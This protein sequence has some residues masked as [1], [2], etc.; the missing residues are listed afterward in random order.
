MNIL[1]TGNIKRLS[2]SFF[3]SVAGIDNNENLCVLYNEEADERE[4]NGNELRDNLDR[5]RGLSFI[6]VFDSGKGKDLE[7]LFKSYSF[8]MIVYF[9]KALDG[10][11]RFYDELEDLEEN[12]FLANK[13]KVPVFTQIVTNDIYRENKENSIASRN[14]RML[15]LTGERMGYIS[16]SNDGVK[17]VTLR[18]PRLYSHRE[19]AW[20]LSL[21][22]KELI[23]NSRVDFSGAKDEDTD[24]LN[25][26]DLGELIL[27]IADLSPASDY[28]EMNLSG[29]NECNLEQIADC[30]KEAYADLKDYY[31][32]KTY[33]QPVIKKDE[34]ARK[35]YGWYPKH[36]IRKEIPEIIEKQQ[37]DHE[38]NIIKRKRLEKIRKFTD[39]TRVGFEIIA[40]ACLA[41]WL[42]KITSGN[43]ILGFIDFR[44]IAVVIIGSMNGL[45]PGLMSA[46]FASIAYLLISHK[47]LSWQMLLLNVQNWLPFVSYFLLGAVTGYGKD[48]HSDEVKEAAQERK[49][50]EKK[51]EFLNKTYQDV[52]ES[53]ERKKS[54]IIGYTDSY[55]KIYGAIKKLD[56]MSPE[57]VYFEG[58]QVLENLLDNDSIAIYNVFEN[59][60]FARLA[61]C[62]KKENG[63]LAKSFDLREFPEMTEMLREGRSFINIKCLSSYP[64]YAC[65]IM[66]KGK[67]K[68]I[69]EIVN[70]EDYQMNNEFH[71]KLY[72]ISRLI[73]SSLM[74]AIDEQEKTERFIEGT[75]VLNKENFARTLSI[76]KQMN[77]RNFA[78]YTLIR[79]IPV[80]PEV[81]IYSPDAIGQVENSLSGIIR[82]NDIIGIGEDDTM[83]ILLLQTGK[84][85]AA[86]VKERL[87]LNEFKFE[88]VE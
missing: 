57:E 77:L 55:G 16:A 61:V 69:V 42:N 75:H 56:L 73:S 1:F 17:V 47:T 44:I 45:M 29:G 59:K 81:D 67:L 23:K 40:M 41:E 19:N 3:E 18:V 65:P 86:K 12:L 4:K 60:I 62:S 70:A 82:N 66:E 84:A 15:L 32:N 11:G 24:F 20:E 78:D 64:A 21:W 50:L 79:L 31:D 6:R 22:V 85:G 49:V 58:V 34:Q 36:N 88:E 68:G 72:I 28:T 2:S 30:F 26:E 87:K 63:N 8:G 83:W 33:V 54:Q 52:L 51:Y 27:R 74:K 71:N 53:V 43:A 39:A 38:K 9:S 48:K 14:R 7:T 46:S 10:A 35:G 5:L 76:Y 25:D 37:N 80:R 13:Y